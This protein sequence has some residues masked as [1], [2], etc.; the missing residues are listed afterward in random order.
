MFGYSPTNNSI[1]PPLLNGW[2]FLYSFK[3]GGVNLYSN[4]TPLPFYFKLTLGLMKL[5]NMPNLTCLKSLKNQHWWQ[6]NYVHA[7]VTK[8]GFLRHSFYSC[9]S[10]RQNFRYQSSQLIIYII[11]LTA[12]ASP[13]HCAHQ[14][15]VSY[16]AK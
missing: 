14:N 6:C 1:D 2:I 11:S 9:K 12:Q 13:L 5:L 3:I 4:W 16:S 15:H 10:A 7:T 8:K